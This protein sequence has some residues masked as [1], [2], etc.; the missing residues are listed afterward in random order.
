MTLPGTKIE[1]LSLKEAAQLSPY[2]ADYLNLLARKGKIKC[3]KLGRDWVVSKQDLH[4]YLKHQ[5]GA[6][7]SKLRQ[8]NRYI[9]KISPMGRIGLEIKK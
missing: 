9:N 3:V 2:S 8:L 6:S 7:R 5:E 4:D 1:L